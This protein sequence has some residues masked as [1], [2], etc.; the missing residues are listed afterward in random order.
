MIGAGRLDRK[1]IIQRFTT[2]Q[3]A[4]GEPIETW[5]DHI[6]TWA[7]VLPQTG[8]EWFNSQ[9]ELSERAARFVFRFEDDV[10]VKD[11]ISYD[12]EYWDILNINEIN[13]REGLEIV[14]KVTE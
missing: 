14:A 4:Y 13:R 9:R 2:T 6:T 5:V 11:R 3:D 8:R 1:I 7:N 12:G 10:T